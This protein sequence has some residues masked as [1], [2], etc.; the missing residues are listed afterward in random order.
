MDGIDERP[1]KPEKDD[2]QHQDAYNYT[3]GIYNPGKGRLTW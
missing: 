2:F 3:E 1:E